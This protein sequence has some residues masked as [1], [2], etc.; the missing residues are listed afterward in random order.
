[1]GSAVAR[2]KFVTVTETHERTS[3]LYAV[4]LG[5]T[6]ISVVVLPFLGVAIESTKPAT[7]LA[8]VDR[9]FLIQGLLYALSGI[10]SGAV[11]WTLLIKRDAPQRPWGV[12]LAGVV[13]SVLVPSLLLVVL[14]PS[15]TAYFLLYVL[16]TAST[17]LGVF[18]VTS[19]AFAVKRPARS[20][21]IDAS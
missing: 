6:L 8:S 5:C 14:P 4:V 16:V 21:P 18:I 1:M 11:A 17:L 20:T 19:I 9:F 3:R 12:V 2:G 15:A 7:R 13:T 10:A